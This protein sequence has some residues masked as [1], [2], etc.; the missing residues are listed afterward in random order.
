MAMI[1]RIVF[2]LLAV[3]WPVF[4][5]S[6][7]HAD[8]NFDVTAGAKLV[9]DVNFGTIDVTHGA[10]N[11]IAVNVYRKIDGPNET[12][13]KEYLASAPLTIVKEGNTDRKSTRLNSSHLV[14]SY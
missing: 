3:A 2:L 6:E 9:V 7:Q 1:I 5:L 12:L 4:A 14:I 10:E 13:E 8:E 11:K